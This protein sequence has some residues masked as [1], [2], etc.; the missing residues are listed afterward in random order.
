MKIKYDPE[1]DAM[2]I[3]LREGDVH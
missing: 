3:K 1:A 2:Y